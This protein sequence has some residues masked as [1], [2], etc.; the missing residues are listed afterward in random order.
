LHGKIRV[1]QCK[2]GGKKHMQLNWKVFDVLLSTTN[3]VVVLSKLKIM[4]MNFISKTLNPTSIATTFNPKSALKQHQTL[5]IESPLGE[6]TLNIGIGTIPCIAD[7]AHLTIEFSANGGDENIKTK[8]KKKKT[9]LKMG[10]V[11]LSN[12]KKHMTKRKGW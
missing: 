10:K 7:D 12:V 4:I 5:I 6:L 3:N 2:N 1:E 8:S 9:L 11:H